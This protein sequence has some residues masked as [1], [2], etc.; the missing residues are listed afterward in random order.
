MKIGYNAMMFRYPATGSGQYLKR[1]I[2][3]EIV[4][5]PAL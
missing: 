5:G 4:A 1:K 3:S 2:P